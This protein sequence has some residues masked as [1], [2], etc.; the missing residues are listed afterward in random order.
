MAILD[1]LIL[2][3]LLLLLLLLPMS[4]VLL[5]ILPHTP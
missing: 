2:L 1:M 4:E 3:L 5:N